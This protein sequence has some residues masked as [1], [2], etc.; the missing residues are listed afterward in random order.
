LPR[1]M[2]PTWSSSIRYMI[3]GGY[4]DAETQRRGERL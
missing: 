3:A 2:M 1:P 4:F